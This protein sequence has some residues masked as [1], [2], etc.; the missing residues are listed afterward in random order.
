MKIFEVLKIELIKRS[1]QIL[2]RNLI[3]EDLGEQVLKLSVKILDRIYL[4]ICIIIF[5]VL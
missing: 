5:K 2:T 1:L 3:F 4:K